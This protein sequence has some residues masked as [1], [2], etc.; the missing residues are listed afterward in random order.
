MGGNA[1]SPLSI[2]MHNTEICTYS[3][4]DI[5]IFNQLLSGKTIHDDAATNHSLKQ[6]TGYTLTG[7]DGTSPD[8]P[9]LGSII[10]NGEQLNNVVY[11]PNITYKIHSQ[12]QLI[13]VEKW[14]FQRADDLSIT[15]GRFIDGNYQER[16]YARETS[17]THKVLINTTMEILVLNIHDEKHASTIRKMQIEHENSGHTH[18]TTMVEA[19]EHYA[20]HL[21]N[22]TKFEAYI[23]L[24][25]W[26]AS[27]GHVCDGCLRGRSI[28]RK[29][30]RKGRVIYTERI[31]Y[32]D[33]EGLHMDCFFF[34]TEYVFIIFTSH[35]F[36][37][38]WTMQLHI[39]FDTLLIKD[40]IE[41]VFGH[42]RYT[43]Q[44]ISFIRSDPDH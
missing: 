25:Y 11:L 3:V 1:N 10:E 13:E 36:Q 43:G 30:N 17:E 8:A 22:Y 15:Y 37:M 9:Y 26:E 5:V 32:G 20:P 38:T 23:Y 14:R 33:K 28:R 4:K 12:Y 16:T 39:G 18:P 35:K 27:N 44:T 21:L 34:G 29:K 24:K 31:R 6:R 40:K 19:A 42:Y 41:E 2:Q 7:A